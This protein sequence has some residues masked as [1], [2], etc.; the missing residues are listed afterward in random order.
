MTKNNTDNIHVPGPSS[1]DDVML[2]YLQEE[3]AESSQVDGKLIPTH[4]N[5]L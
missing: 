2:Q 5:K 1:A 4:F 3:T